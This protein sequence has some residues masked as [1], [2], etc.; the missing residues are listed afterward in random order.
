MGGLGGIP[1]E[2]EL[3]YLHIT[4]LYVSVAQSPGTF[5]L[6]SFPMQLV[7]LYSFT[8][9]SLEKHLDHAGKARG[10]ICD[11]W[12]E[13]SCSE[14][15]QPGKAARAGAAWLAEDMERGSKS[16]WCLE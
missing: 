4:Q 2:N 8:E 12:S 14:P 13:Q 3:F 7:P 11:A 1:W 5:K 9:M 10:V 15:V 6:V 16:K